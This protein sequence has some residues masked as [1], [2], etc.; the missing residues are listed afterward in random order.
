M[1]TGQGWHTTWGRLMRNAV[2]DGIITADERLALRGLKHRGVTDTKGNKKE[3]SGHITDS[4]LHVYDHS[5]PV[6]SE[7]GDDRESGDG[8]TVVTG[9]RLGHQ[10]AS[11]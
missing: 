8:E 10:G 1:L 2:R 11:R 9:Q 6:V 5:L 4:M 3:A 7:A